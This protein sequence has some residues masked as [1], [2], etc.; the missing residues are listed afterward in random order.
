MYVDAEFI[1]ANIA[2]SA[3][4]SIVEQ[5]EVLQWRPAVDA[6]P[7]APLFA[8]MQCDLAASRE[9]DERWLAG[10]FALV[11]TRPELLVHVFAS[12]DLIDRGILTLRL[13]KHGAWQP[14]TIDTMVPCGADGRPSFCCAGDCEVLWPSLLTKAFAKLY[15]SYAALA[16]GDLS[17]A[18]ID[19][20]AGH[21]A[22]ES[23]DALKPEPPTDS[24]P[25]EREL[26]QQYLD[27]IWRMLSRNAKRGMLQG[28][29]THPPPDRRPTNIISRSGGM[30]EEEGEEEGEGGVGAAAAGE[31]DHD[32]SGLL[33]DCLYPI[34][35][36]R[37]PQPGLRLVCL[38][39]PWL[40]QV[41]PSGASLRAWAPGSIEWTRHTHI[42]EQLL[43][44]SD[45]AGRC[46][47]MEISDFAKA[48][49]QLVTVEVAGSSTE[50]VVCEG[51]WRAGETA[52]G[53]RSSPTWCINP[54]YWITVSKDT[55]LTIEVSQPDKRLPTERPASSAA[56]QARAQAAAG[57][58]RTGGGAAVDHFPGIDGGRADSG[59]GGGADELGEEEEEEG[60]VGGANAGR[61]LPISVCVIRGGPPSTM[62]YGRVWQ[63]DQGKAL[64]GECAPKKRRSVGLTVMLHADRSYCVVPCCSVGGVS[65]FVLRLQSEV[66]F[67]L[68]QAQPA[69]VAQLE[70][71]WDAASA[72]GPR[73]AKT[74]L[75]N[76]QYW[77]TIRPPPTG[78][79]LSKVRLH[80][81]SHPPTPAQQAVTKANA[82]VMGSSVGGKGA[83]ARTH[84]GSSGD[85]ALE[86][87]DCGFVLLK[88]EFNRDRFGRARAPGAGGSG[89]VSPPASRPGTAPG[90]RSP[91]RNGGRPGS[92]GGS[93]RGKERPST[94]RDGG[95]G[96][97][98]GGAQ[99]GFETVQGY[100]QL[101]EFVSMDR[102]H[103]GII[104]AGELELARRL[105]GSGPSQGA[106]SS[107]VAL[108]S[109]QEGEHGGGGGG[110]FQHTAE[111]P[112]IDEILPPA[113]PSP[114]PDGSTLDLAPVGSYSLAFGL[115]VRDTADSAPVR[116]QMIDKNTELI[117]SHVAESHVASQVLSLD[118]GLPYVISVHT[119]KPGQAAHYTLRAYSDSLLSLSLIETTSQKVLRGAWRS[120]NSGGS[121]I[122][123][124]AKWTVN[125]Q[126]ALTLNAPTTV[127]ITLERPANKW[128]RL[129]KL[130][131]L[132]AMMGFYVIRGEVANT[133]MRG[134][135]ACL[136]SIVHQS[137]FLPAMSNSVSLH[138]EPL[139]DGAPYLIMPAT[140]GVGMNGPFSLGVNA[141]RPCTFVALEEAKAGG[142]GGDFGSP[143]R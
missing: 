129:Q 142:G 112:P 2:V 78:T 123:S 74:W 46:I 47:W 135:R 106:N 63:G 60:G 97:S 93:P 67:T 143:G 54:Q 8:E 141:D 16:G 83:A 65:P 115:P 95:G 29:L 139:P 5:F 13:F 90:G 3:D 110:P 12:T 66:S 102:N 52:G 59:Y 9:Y 45:A 122:E 25:D 33:A 69:V 98:G 94:A 15:G 132:E 87:P 30:I 124:P 117:A 14:V 121:H 72:G 34:V 130:N 58:S 111:G 49:D 43:P 77:L 107:L 4:A 138:L 71:A 114:L 89:S 84:G 131:T 17:D 23:M 108:P 68:K 18:L 126:Y 75:T 76:P 133:P 55:A 51:A 62:D 128:Q 42:A 10:A 118:P 38:R 7:N 64:V 24:L 79:A 134:T 11:A 125:P 21:V 50:A 28:G 61:Y 101:V 82:G 119:S 22:Y 127:S 137:T 20:T 35:Y 92:R 6:M 32:A 57:G 26:R 37:E 19:L 39:D 80:L 73:S 96:R 120:S 116:V 100:E 103:D 48:F 88:G 86:P 91:P 41:A 105:K 40:G 85:P 1:P 36:T 104:S 31:D 99:A 53:P 136:E 81:E 44:L 113:G 27:A 56:A 140:F 70:G 109:I